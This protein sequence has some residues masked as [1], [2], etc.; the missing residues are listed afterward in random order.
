MV[1]LQLIFFIAFRLYTICVNQ[2]EYRSVCVSV[3]HFC[4]ANYPKVDELYYNVS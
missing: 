2:K 3:Q 4:V 1:Q